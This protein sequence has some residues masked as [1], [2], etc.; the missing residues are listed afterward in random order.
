MKVLLIVL[1]IIGFPLISY[2]PEV[3]GVDSRVISVPYR[4]VYFLICIFALLRFRWKSKVNI[5]F[6]PILLFI[7][8][9]FLRAVYDNIFQY[10]QV[11]SIAFEFWLFAFLMGFFP[12]FPFLFKINLKTLQYSKNALLIV[13]TVVN[14][15]GLKNNYAAFSDEKVGRF[16]GNEILNP[17]TYGQTGVV[18][19]ILA[20]TFFFE[21]NIF[22]KL[23]MIGLISLGLINVA[24]SA[25]RGPMIELSVTVLCFVVVNFKRIGAL[26]LSVMVG[27]LVGIGIYFKNYLI[28]F[29]LVFDRIGDTGFDKQTGS[30]ERYFLYKDAWHQFW[31]SPFFGYIGI[32]AYP[33][34]LVLESFMALGIFGGLLMIYI[35]FI[36]FR[37]IFALVKVKATDWIALIFLMHTVT[38]FI[39]GAIWN[40]FEFWSLLAFSFTLYGNKVLYKTNEQ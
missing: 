8:L 9:Y 17:I 34:N 36:A 29:T 18:L 3:L 21:K 1:G 25:S 38:T 35:L 28:L 19:V 40:S 5:Y 2:I 22:G 4:A 27:A 14:I 26:S 32:G 24:L 6:L 30:E 20:L 31:E 7:F 13:T 33:H 23:L 10:Q 11:S 12:M 16:L 15:L 37:N 39:S